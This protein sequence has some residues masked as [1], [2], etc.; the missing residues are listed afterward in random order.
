MFHPKHAELFAGN[1]NTGQKKCHLVGT[2]LKLTHGARTD[3]Y[4]IL[5]LIYFC[6]LT[7]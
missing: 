3:E 4:K 2:F 5:Y 6:V 1:K 7:V